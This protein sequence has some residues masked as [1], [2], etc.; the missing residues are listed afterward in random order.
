MIEV[1]AMSH[2]VLPASVSVGLLLVFLSAGTSAQAA[3]VPGDDTFLDTAASFSVL[4]GSTV[5]N[6]GS[7]VLDANLG[8]SPGSALP[9]FPPGLIGGSTHSNDAVAIQAQLDVTTAVNALL[10]VPSFDVGTADLD[11]TTFLAGAYSSASSLLN[12][13]TIT[14]QGDADDVFIFTAVSTLTTGAGSTIVF[15][16][17]VQE[18]NVFWRVGSSATLG[19]GSHMVGTVI[20]SASVSAT[21]GATIAGRLFAQVAAVTLQS[22]VFTAPTCDTAGGDGG[23][24]PEVVVP[25]TETPGGPTGPVLE[26]PETPGPD[27]PGPDTPGPG[28][29]NPTTTPAGTP[30]LAA[31]GAEGASGIAVGAAL[32]TLGLGALAWARRRRGRDLLAHQDVR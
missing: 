11:G 1:T 30:E 22:N 26:I 5:T 2:K 13:G 20:A 31:T 23:T 21:T 27:T 32:L 25:P 10:A 9:G 8:V 12:T 18:C 3:G 24:V 7:S 16:G 14:L 6:T 28:T 15:V 29:D 4:G 19:A 17:D